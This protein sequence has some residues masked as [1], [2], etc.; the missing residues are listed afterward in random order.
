MRRASCFRELKSPA[1][2]SGAL[3]V[4]CAFS[5]EKVILQKGELPEVGGFNLL[6]GFSQRVYISLD[7]CRS[8]KTLFF[9]H[10]ADM[11]IDFLAGL[12]MN[13]KTAFVGASP[14]SAVNLPFEEKFFT[15]N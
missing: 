11:D 7:V 9:I 14:V 12:V 15:L 5:P 8:F 13:H 10:R 4:V 6:A 1:H 3:F 2:F